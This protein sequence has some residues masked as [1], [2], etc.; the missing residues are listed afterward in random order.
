MTDIE[1]IDVENMSP[2]EQ[3]EFLTLN[4]ELDKLTQLCEAFEQQTDQL[5]KESK[6]LAAKL[7]ELNE[8]SR[9]PTA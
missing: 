7:R 1:E 4:A 9:D 5:C 6:E 3:Q 2:E 8:S